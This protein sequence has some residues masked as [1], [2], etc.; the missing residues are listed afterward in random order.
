MPGYLYAEDIFKR[1][2]EKLFEV[3][4]T[5]FKEDEL[6]FS[7]EQRKTLEKLHFKVMPFIM[8]RMKGD[9]LRELPEKIIN[10]YYCSL[11][12]CQMKHYENLEERIKVQ[13]QAREI[14]ALSNLHEMIKIVNHPYLADLESQCNF[15]D[16]GK[17]I[18]L[19]ELF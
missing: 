6:L 2:Y 15:E 11:T 16:S 9:V 13:S 10:D 8:R 12:D 14:N 4:L 3:N 17:F 1:N 5:T 7:E 18:A 19:G